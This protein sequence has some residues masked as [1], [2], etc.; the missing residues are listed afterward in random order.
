MVKASAV[1]KL[2][3]RLRVL[4]FKVNVP[5]P[6]VRVFPLKVVPAIFPTTCSLADGAVVPMPT[7]P[8][9]VFNPVKVGVEEVDISWMVLTAPEL[10]EKLV[11]LKEATPLTEVEA[12]IPERVT[13]P[14]KE[15]GDPE[16]EIPVPEVADT[17]MD[18]L[19]RYE[20]K[21]EPEGRDSADETVRDPPIPTLPVVCSW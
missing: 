20:F 13:V 10:T 3:P 12:S 1:V 14:P 9:V 6:V 5:V 2:P 21:M 17:L 18:E 11:E 7:L 4:L 19:A 16:T 15:T 8:V